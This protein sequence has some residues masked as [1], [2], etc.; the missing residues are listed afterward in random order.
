MITQQLKRLLP[1]GLKRRLKRISSRYTCPFC[2]HAF[3]EPIVIGLD[4]PVLREKQ[5]VGG[6]RRAGGCPNCAS[7]DRERLVFVFLKYVL[8]LFV[9]KDRRILHFAPEKNLSN[10]L[11]EG[12][13][14]EYICADLFTEGY[15]YP[16][17][18]RNMNVLKIPFANDHFDLVIC[19]HVLE[20]VPTD[21]AA[22][23]EIYRVLKPGG[24]AILQVPI[25]ANSPRTFE[26]PT[27]VDPTQKELA[28]GQFDHIRIYGQD[29]PDRLRLSGFHVQRINISGRFKKYALNLREDLFICSK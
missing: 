8:K 15:R 16:S 26:D 17:Y 5:V 3:N 22:M 25:S 10:A 28:F 27:I 23:K 1:K 11:F 12:G 7:Q 4:L 13:F 9:R 19:N 29:Y 14:M 2:G 20:H 18:V 6:G 24:R 21:L